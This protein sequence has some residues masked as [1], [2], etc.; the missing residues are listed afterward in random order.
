LASDERNWLETLARLKNNLM[1]LEFVRAHPGT[2]Q[3]ELPGDLQWAQAPFLW[4]HAVWDTV[5]NKG[6]VRLMSLREANRNQAFYRLMTLIGTQSLADWDA[7]NDAHRFDL[8]DTDPTHLSPQ[9]L[10]ETIQLTEIALEK[11]IQ[12]GDSLG[13]YAHEF[14]ELPHTVTWDRIDRLRPSALETDPS[15]MAAAHQRTEDR[16]K[17]AMEEGSHAPDAAAPIQSPK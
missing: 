4:D 2:P 9:Q 12:F 6:I 7:I 3:T 15:G 10:N 8:L 11:H 14:P 17:A 1:V 16:I 5:E 13:R